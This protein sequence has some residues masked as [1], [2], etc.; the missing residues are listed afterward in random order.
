MEVEAT[1]RGEEG[2]DEVILGSRSADR[3]TAKDGI[4]A[5][6]HERRLEDER[7]RVRRRNSRVVDERPLAPRARR[8]RDVPR[9]RS[10]R[11]P[12]TSRST[13]SAAADLNRRTRKRPRQRELVG[14]RSDR[15]AGGQH[16][17]LRDADRNRHL[18]RFAALLGAAGMRNEMASAG[19]ADQCCPAVDELHPVHATLRAPGLRVAC[20]VDVPGAEIAS[21]ILRRPSAA[22]E[23]REVDV[24]PDIRH[25]L[26]VVLRAR[27]PAA[28]GRSSRAR[29]TLRTSR[30]ERRGRQA[31][32]DADPP[33]RAQRVR[34]DP[35][36]A[37]IR[38]RTRRA[39][40]GCG[41]CLGARACAHL[42]VPVDLF[43]DSD[44]LVRL[45]ESVDEP[46]EARQRSSGDADA[47]SMERSATG[48]DDY[49]AAWRIRATFFAE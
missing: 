21:R 9:S 48:C 44:E 2:I 14:L 15:H 36:A 6:A 13:S 22:P 18:E 17:G 16:Q 10:P 12:G 33:G 19:R 29:T 43:A 49:D 46:S 30:N 28:I 45:L 3:R 23:A 42:Q 40:R 39:P 24:L 37:G 31:E 5:D 4:P 7:T 20:Q 1:R 26:D 8:A 47:R 41:R 25:A 11:P 34:Q 38:E 27:P 32:R 35:C